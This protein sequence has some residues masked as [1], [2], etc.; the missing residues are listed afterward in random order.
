[1]KS[2]DIIDGLIPG[3]PLEFATKDNEQTFFESVDS[4]DG[5]DYV[6][7]VFLGDT[8]IGVC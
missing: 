2:I 7:S 1:M 3:S 6:V 5:S 4:S 8:L